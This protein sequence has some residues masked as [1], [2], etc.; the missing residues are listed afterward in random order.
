[1]KRK[2]F[3]LL[4]AVLLSMTFIPLGGR[5]VQA[6]KKPK[7][8]KTRLT[9]YQG[10]ETVLT[11]KNYKKAISWSSKYPAVATVTPTGI[12]RG[13]KPG[14]TTI[15]A[16]YK[17]KTLKCYVTVLPP[18]P[19]TARFTGTPRQQFLAYLNYYSTYIQTHPLYFKREFDDK[20]VSFAHAVQKVNLN[21]K[22]GIT[23][24][25]PIRWA[26]KDM[27]IG[28]HIKAEKGKFKSFKGLMPIYLVKITQGPFVGK[29]FKEAVDQNLLMPGDIIALKKK[30]H[31]F[32]YSGS[33]YLC[34][35]GGAASKAKGY[36]NIGILVDYSKMYKTDGITQILR[37]KQ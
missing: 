24:V 20:L 36:H 1:M 31:T 19:V 33:G 3:L 29:T 6:K 5:T 18:L 25:V 10:K 12:I 9:L 32:A 26:M 35:D 22:A 4:T 16:K 13:I 7:L 34:Y 28:G 11:V 14:K 2:V 37:W 30:T 17:K 21:K 8:S 27:G 15:Y 23:C